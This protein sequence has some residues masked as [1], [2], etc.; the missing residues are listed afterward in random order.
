MGRNGGTSKMSN[1]DAALDRL[2]DAVASL[3]ASTGGK[4]PGAQIAALTAERDALKSEIEA[5]NIKRDEDAQLRAEAADAVRTA[6]VDL[7]SVMAAKEAERNAAR[8]KAG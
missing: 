6:L 1:L 5:L 7:R 4:P 8:K 2:G 3:S